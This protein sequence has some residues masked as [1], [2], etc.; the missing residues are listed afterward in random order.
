MSRLQDHSR[1]F[2]LETALKQANEG[3]GLG[4]HIPGVV[5]NKRR[6]YNSIALVVT[7]VPTLI[8]YLESIHYYTSGAA[9]S[10]AD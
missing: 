1:I 10:E 9:G 2:A 5:I 3:S 7:A 8:T 4:F 6:L